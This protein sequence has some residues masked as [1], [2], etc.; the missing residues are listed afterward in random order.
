[1]I[2]WS[3]LEEKYFIKTFSHP[4]RSSVCPI[5]PSEKVAPHYKIFS[6]VYRGQ[7]VTTSDCVENHWHFEIQWES[8][9]YRTRICGFSHIS[10][11][12]W[13]EWSNFIELSPL[14][15]YRIYTYVRIIRF[16]MRVYLIFVFLLICSTLERMKLISTDHRKLYIVRKLYW[17]RR[18][19]SLTP[20]ANVAYCSV[21]GTMF[22]ATENLGQHPSEIRI[23]FLCLTECSYM[24]NARNF[25]PPTVIRPHMPVS[26]P[27]PYRQEIF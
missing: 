13:S 1:M 10:D 12:F 6:M 3:L 9:M 20:W 14:I 11:I 8:D 23:A 7:A 27:S 25:V 17:S 2:S 5:S 16:K 18:S 21:G 19:F 24:K 15:G 22:R 26:H 4:Y